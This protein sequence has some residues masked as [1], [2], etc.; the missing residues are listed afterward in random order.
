MK[1]VLIID[2]PPLFREFLKNKLTTEGIQVEFANGRRDA[3]TK[4]LN[5]L[6]DLVIIDTAND[7][8]QLTDLLKKKQENPNAKK[9]PVLLTGPVLSRDQVQELPRY[10]VSKYFNKPIKFD[11]FFESIGHILK[12]PLSIDT[13]QC[14]MDVHLNDNIIFIEIAQG[15]NREKMALLKYKISELLDDNNFTSPKIV[16]MLTNLKLSFIDGA[17]LELLLDNITADSRI[18]K[19]NVKILSFDHFT[20]ELING[21]TQYKGIEVTQNLAAVLNSLVQGDSGEIT[22]LINNKILTSTDDAEQGSIQMKFYSE[23][24]VLDNTN[25]NHKNPVIA[26]VDDE[27]VTR[28]LLQNAFKQ[29]HATCELFESGTDFLYASNT[30][31]YDLI[32]LDI[33]MPG[34]SGFDILTRLHLQKYPSPVLI[35]SQATQ[36]KAVIQ[37]LSLGAKS[38]LVKPLKAQEIIKK[39]QEIMNAKF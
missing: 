3:F 30:K 13:T 6:P 18:L 2:E 10:N 31:V 16:L 23:S 26:I 8:T 14:I 11:I 9:I 17:N 15:L 37:A 7:Y 25:A 34:L 1:Q 38:Y 20:K 12:L 35:Y 4:M 33:F 36:R 24:G 32:V 21:H 27:I 39:A 22:D 28:T 19:K 29:I 5:I